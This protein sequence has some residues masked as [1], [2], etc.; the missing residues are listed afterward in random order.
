MAIDS[1]HFPRDEL[2][3]RV[4]RLLIDGPGT[5]LALFAPRRTG[6]TEFLS[7]DLAPVADKLRHRV[8]YV[9]FWEAPASPLAVLLHALEG[10][11]RKGSWTDRVRDNAVALAP[12]LRLSAP[13]PGTNAEA[14]IDLGALKAEVPSE[15]LLYLG[16]LIARVANDRRP[17]LLMLDEVQELARDS[18]NRPLI[19]ALRTAL[20]T[21]KAGLR[22]VFTGSSQQGLQAMFDDREAPFFHFATPLDLPPLDRPFVE[23]LCEIARDITDRSLDVD[24]AFEVFGELHANPYFFRL[25]VETL[26]LYP[27]LDMAEAA[28]R[29]RTRVAAGLGY[30]DVWLS[31]DP[32]RRA[33]TRALADGVEQPFGA[34]AREALVGDERDIAVPTVSQVQTAMKTLERRRVIDTWNGRR[35]IA[36]PAFAAWV[37]EQPPG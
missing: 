1:W 24:V 27:D 33:L 20:D 10:S 11:L 26:V 31:L 14:E 5:A 13:L 6:K 9:S 34:P 30:A 15:L 21:N 19:A 18:G 28:R 32:L 3:R 8:I 2:A 7:F 12:K 37:R 29:V 4:L 35:V 16:D 17:T 36:D 22:T 23:H 25:A